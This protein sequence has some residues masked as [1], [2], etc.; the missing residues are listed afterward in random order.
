MKFISPIGA[1]CTAAEALA[2]DGR[3]KAG[4]RQI[5]EHGE[6]IRFDVFAADAA[7]ASRQSLYLTD[8]EGPASIDAMLQEEI[9]SRA[10]VQG[11][12]PSEYLAS[13]STIA[14]T[15]IVTEV[16]ERFL[17]QAGA[18]GT[19]K[20]LAVDSNPMFRAAIDVQHAAHD[21]KFDNL[22]DAAPAFDRERAAFLL[23]SAFNTG[24]QVA[25][26]SP[27][28]QTASPVADSAAFAAARYS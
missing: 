7:P 3:T 25:G 8:A 27:A 22:G 17:A 18:N 6:S 26:L 15:K 19:A 24:L 12:K 14:L 11:K 1:E 5:I 16:A 20:A 9:T 10:K 13:L 2:A 21:T 28:R 23:Q 4:Y